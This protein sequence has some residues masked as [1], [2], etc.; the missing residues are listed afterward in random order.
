MEIAV[1]ITALD[2]SVVLA[3][4]LIQSPFAQEVDTCWCV[5]DQ[6]GCQ[7]DLKVDLN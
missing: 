2:D 7:R 3:A 5:S 4:T 6:T 1:I